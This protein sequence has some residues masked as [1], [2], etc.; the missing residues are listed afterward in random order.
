MSPP[1]PPGPEVS[2][3]DDFEMLIYERL[4]TVANDRLS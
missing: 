2:S 3:S 1:T 4:N